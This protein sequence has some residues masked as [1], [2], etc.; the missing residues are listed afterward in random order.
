MFEGPREL[1]EKALA[2]AQRGKLDDAIATYERL[3]KQTPHDLGA[4]QKMAE[5]LVRNRCVPEAIAAYQTVAGR[6]AVDGFLLKAIAICKIILELDP[7]HSETQDALA[8]L[9]SRKRRTTQHAL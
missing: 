5:A 1:Q 4:R 8:N 7:A 6:Y 9:Y 3:L 2:Y